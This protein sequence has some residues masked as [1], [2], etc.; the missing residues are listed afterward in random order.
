MFTV[1]SES[2]L[3]VNQSSQDYSD[4]KPVQSEIIAGVLA[5]VSPGVA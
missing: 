1:L 4:S 5:P 3:R 2:D